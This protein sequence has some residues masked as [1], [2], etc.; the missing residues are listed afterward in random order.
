MKTY[1]VVKPFL[2]PKAEFLQH[3][4]EIY[5]SGWITNSGPKL[6]KLERSL[7]ECLGVKNIILVTNGTVAL[8]LAYRILDIPRK[9]ILTT[10][11]SFIATASSIKWAGFQPEFVDIRHDT[12]NIDESLLE[13]VDEPSAICTTHVFGNP[14]NVD[15]IETLRKKHGLKVIYDGAHAFGVNYNGESIFNY[16]D[17]STLSFHATKVFHTIEGGA[18]VINDEVLASKARIAINFGIS[19]EDKIGTLGVNYKMNEIQAAMGLAGL[20]HISVNYNKRKILSETYWDSLKPAVQYQKWA[21]GASN[22]YSYMPVIFDSE[23]KLLLVKENLKKV[24]INIRRYFYPS[25]STLEF[26]GDHPSSC[27]H[28]D[29]ISRRIACLPLYVDLTVEDVKFISKEINKWI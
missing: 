4:D 7:E 26:L 9:K 3:V 11:F 5:E 15:R 18:L 17:I 23:S 27:H 8:D 25:L 24:N 13:K 22:N 10:P 2:P 29:D 6:R 28:A 21:D 14:C 16:G 19:G 1:N 20:N 12:L